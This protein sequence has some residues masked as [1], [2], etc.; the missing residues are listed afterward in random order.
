MKIYKITF[1]KDLYVI[2]LLLIFLLI[3]NFNLGSNQI[4]VIVP[5][6]YERYPFEPMVLSSKNDNVEFD[7]LSKAIYYESS[8]QSRKG[9]AIF[10]K[11]SLVML[12]S[13]RQQE[14][15]HSK[16]KE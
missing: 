14:W 16:L 9:K 2:I 5:V 11:S 8:T 1:E 4:N 6:K 12:L 7:C 10:E 13:L 3:P 15:L